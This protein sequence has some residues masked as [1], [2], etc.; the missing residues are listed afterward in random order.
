MWK[1]LYKIVSLEVLNQINPHFSMYQK[2][3]FQRF[4][5]NFC[6]RRQILLTS[7]ELQVFHPPTI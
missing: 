7:I 3:F 2:M 4:C 5:V 6:L 1:S